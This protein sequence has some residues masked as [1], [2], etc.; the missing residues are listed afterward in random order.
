MT[1]IGAEPAAADVVAPT[2]RVHVTGAA[3]QVLLQAVGSVILPTI[4]DLVAQQGD[5]PRAEVRIGRATV[6]LLVGG[7][8]MILATATDLAAKAA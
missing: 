6:I 7:N 5:R 1:G 2:C 8:G 4:A 3:M